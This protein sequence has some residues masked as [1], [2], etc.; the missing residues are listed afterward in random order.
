MILITASKS[1][2]VAG[3][4]RFFSSGS[5]LIATFGICPFLVAFPTCGSSVFKVSFDGLNFVGLFYKIFF[6][7]SSFINLYF[8]ALLVILARAC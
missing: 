8:L 5:N 6:Y 3:L 7:I 2:L 1:L 4:F